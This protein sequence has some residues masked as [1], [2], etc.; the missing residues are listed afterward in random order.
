MLNLGVTQLNEFGLNKP[1]THPIV[2]HNG[3]AV[4]IASP[5]TSTHC[6]KLLPPTFALS[7]FDE[8]PQR[9]GPTLE[10]EIFGDFNVEGFN[11]D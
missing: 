1:N 6:L 5:A 9:S 4:D 11:G 7:L 8:M 2:T 10:M 3:N